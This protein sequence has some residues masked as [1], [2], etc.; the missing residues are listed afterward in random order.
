[1]IVFMYSTNQLSQSAKAMV[2]IAVPSD[3]SSLPSDDTSASVEIE[4]VKVVELE[5]TD[6][7]STEPGFL[8]GSLAL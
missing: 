2:C 5:G 8:L 3:S 7:T 4:A 1:M 6:S